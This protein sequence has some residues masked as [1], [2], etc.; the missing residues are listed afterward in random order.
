MPNMA[1][2]PN[3]TSVPALAGVVDGY[4]DALYRL[5]S[6]FGDSQLE[7]GRTVTDHIAEQPIEVTL[8]GFVSDFDIADGADSGTSRTPAD[9]FDALRRIHNERQVFSLMTEWGEFAEMGMKRC[10]PRHS[11]RGMRFELEVREIQ[12]VGVPDPVPATG[13][14]SGRGGGV[15]RGRVPLEISAE[16]ARTLE[17]AFAPAA[18]TSPLTYDDVARQTPMVR[19]LGGT[20]D[21]YIAPEVA[22]S[23]TQVELA[24][25]LTENERLL[26]GAVDLFLQEQRNQPL[27]TSREGALLRQFL[28]GSGQDAWTIAESV[29]ETQKFDPRRFTGSFEDIYRIVQSHFA[30]DLPSDPSTLEQIRDGYIDYINP[31]ERA[32]RTYEWGKAAAGG[33]KRAWNWLSNGFDTDEQTLAQARM[34]P[35]RQEQ[36]QQYN[37]LTD[38]DRKQYAREVL[39]EGSV[40]HALSSISS[41]F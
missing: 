32:E 25:E 27:P 26:L 24:Q 30:L 3:G 34:G 36:T 8:T 38:H 5:Q 4:P 11:G 23:L 39:E 28:T 22:A 18:F 37:R 21:D 33:V 31:V 41:V 16:Y 19:F 15:A 29:K 13:P 40:A 14:A 35:R 7:D 6:R 1:L 10:E 20:P 2:I 12:R 17:L 9:A